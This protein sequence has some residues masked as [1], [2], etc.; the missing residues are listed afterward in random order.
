MNKTKANSKTSN[1][2]KTKTSNNGKI[3]N[4]EYY[5]V[6]INKAIRLFVEAFNGTKCYMSMNKNN[7]NVNVGDND[8]SEPDRNKTKANG[9]FFGIDQGCIAP[10]VTN[11]TNNSFIRNKAKTNGKERKTKANS[12]T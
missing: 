4:G 8:H 10:L 9:N 2:N 12:N 5:N 1:K 3:G 7:V 11:T 6:R